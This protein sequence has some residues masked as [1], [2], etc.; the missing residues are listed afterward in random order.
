VVRA[1]FVRIEGGS[2][3]EVLRVLS[4]GRGPYDLRVLPRPYR[5]CSISLNDQRIY[6]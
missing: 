1:E 3:G 4:F 5:N 6:P 2:A